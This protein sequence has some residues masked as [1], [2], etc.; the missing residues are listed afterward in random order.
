M[1]SDL[2]RIIVDRPRSSGSEPKGCRKN[3]SK[4]GDD[5]PYKESMKYRFRTGMG[6]QKESSDTLSAIKGFLRK[7]VNRPWDKV[8]A[9][10]CNECDSKS[11]LGHHA[12]EH[13]LQYVNLNVIDETKDSAGRSYW[14]PFYVC[15]NTKLL[16]QVKNKSRK[17]RREKGVYHWA[18]NE[19]AQFK[20]VD[21][22]WYKFYLKEFSLHKYGIYDIFSQRAYEQHGAWE[23][24]NDAYRNWGGMYYAYSKLQLNSKEIKKNKLRSD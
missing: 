22:V 11:V 4:W 12:R 16:K 24:T 23:F 2:K 9:E 7:N 5:L 14:E 3:T 10:F 15:P 18:K 6:N 19:L 1:R 17:Y 8:F 13:L 20:M 21:G